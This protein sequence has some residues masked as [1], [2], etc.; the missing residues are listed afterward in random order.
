MKDVVWGS[1]S[2]SDGLGASVCGSDSSTKPLFAPVEDLHSL[3]VVPSAEEVGNLVSASSLFNLYSPC[4]HQSDNMC[5]ISWSS[6]SAPLSQRFWW[7][8]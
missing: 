8:R 6:L 7:L 5:L 1:G 2:L 4:V 3:W